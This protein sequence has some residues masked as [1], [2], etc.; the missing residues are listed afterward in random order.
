MRH[1]RWSIWGGAIAVTG[2]ILV[3]GSRDGALGTTDSP[4]TVLVCCAAI[5]AVVANRPRAARTA[6][7]VAG[8][9][10]LDQ[11]LRIMTADDNQVVRAGRPG[12]ADVD[13]RG[14][15]R[16]PQ[17]PPP[18]GQSRQAPPRRIPRFSLEGVTNAQVSVHPFS[19][20]DGLGLNLTRFCRAACDDVVLLIHGLTTSSDLFI[21]PEHRNLVSSLLDEG[22]TDVWVLDF[23][24]SNR[25]PY[26]MDTDRYTL[27]DI[28]H[29]DH[30]AAVAEMRRHIGDRR[31]HV[32]A[33]CL[34]SVSFT[35]SLF[36]GA[37]DNIA[38]VISNSVA[39]TPRVPAWS[40]VKLVAGP[41]LLDYVI[42][43]PFI[44]PRFGTARPF[45]KGWL[46]AK[47][48]SLFHRECDVRSCH[49]VSF[50]WGSGRPAM[51]E[52]SSLDPVSHE[53]T[54]DIYGPCDVNY[55]RHMRKMV[56]SGRAV[57]YEPGDP[58]HAELPTDYLEHAAD[59]HTP[60]LFIT[61]DKNRVFSDSNVVCHKV[62][63]EETPGQYE[64]AV[65]PGYG[66]QDPIMGKNAYRDV[67]P[68][69]IAFLKKNAHP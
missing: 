63:S 58:Q 35:M 3:V 67:F 4:I 21:M 7:A 41:A 36:G 39:L 27:D 48:V 31:V 6:P 19:T 50:M 1:Q 45:T 18:A 68:H 12:S 17:P 51:Y 32:I 56:R 57:Q 65:V 42:G 44:D 11:V 55:Y 43:L 15:T 69:M 61:G 28:A 46:F 22:F 14:S 16:T 40:R 33:H 66:H 26:N 24:M 20:E 25:F 54:A 10:D 29:Y 23:R 52:H 37:V 47:M 38:S 64:L 59:I 9:A 13:H 49:M 53:R 5:A 30:P 34:G 60:V 62:L 2:V 8:N